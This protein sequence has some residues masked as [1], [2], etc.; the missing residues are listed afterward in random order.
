MPLLRSR[1]EL[2]STAC[3]V[4][5]AVAAFTVSALAA[6]PLLVLGVLLTLRARLRRR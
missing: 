6:A 1:A 2:A 3:F 5:F 4:L